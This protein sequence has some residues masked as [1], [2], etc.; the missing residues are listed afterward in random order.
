VKTTKIIIG[1]KDFADFEVLGLYG[2]EVKT[3]T[4]AYTSSLHCHKIIPFIKNDEKWVN[5]SFLDPE[6]PKYHEKEFSFKIHKIRKVK[7]SNG[8]VEERISIK[9]KIT[10]FKKKI[11][12]ELTLTERANMKYP[13]LLGRKF[14]SKRF[15]VDTAQIN[16]S[17]N[18]KCIEIDI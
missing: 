8:A 12:V 15:L 5:C 11:P 13:V 10:L 3:D 17:F 7:S 1:R 18:N 14:L 4:G 16:L 6:H 9:T 2:I